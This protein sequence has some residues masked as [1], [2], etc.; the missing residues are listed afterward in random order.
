MRA[1]MA[2]MGRVMTATIALV[3]LLAAVPPAALAE[4]D[5]IWS[6]WASEVTNR[7]SKV[8]AAFA[9]VFSLPA[10]IVI[11]PF[12]WVELAMEKLSGDD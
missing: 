1:K 5:G 2:R 12:W 9:V 6:Q 8:E 7:N 10:M 11:T 4:G 3:A